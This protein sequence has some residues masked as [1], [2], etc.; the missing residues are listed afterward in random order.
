MTDP[1][2]GWFGSTDSLMH[3]LSVVGADRDPD[4]KY[5]V[6]GT[7]AVGLGGQEVVVGADAVYFRDGQ[8]A[9][10]ASNLRGTSYGMGIV[11]L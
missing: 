7:V 4:G 3:F 8:P 11:V 1:K 10:L 9:G 6:A 5:L 2:T